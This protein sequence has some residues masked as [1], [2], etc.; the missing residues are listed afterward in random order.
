MELLGKRVGPAVTGIAHQQS[1]M[2]ISPRVN[3]FICQ[4]VEQVTRRNLC[5]VHHNAGACI[6]SYFKPAKASTV[7]HDVEPVKFLVGIYKCVNFCLYSCKSFHGSPHLDY[8][9]KEWVD[10]AKGI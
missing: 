7:C 6:C 8:L 10:L 5:A 3:P 1:H 9:P 2:I 4:Q